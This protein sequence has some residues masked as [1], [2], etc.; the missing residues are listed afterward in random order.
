MPQEERRPAD[1]VLI[2]HVGSATDRTSKGSFTYTGGS[3]FATAFA[4]AAVL[5]GVGLVAQVGDDFDLDV[6]RRLAINMDGVAILPG[7]SA[8][9]II[10]QSRGG[11][12]SFNSVLGVAAE[13]RFDLFPAAYLRARYVH[14]GTAPTG[15]ILAGLFLALCARGLAE[16]RGFDLLGCGDGPVGDRIRGGWSRRDQ[17]AAAGQGRTGSGDNEQRCVQGLRH[18]L[19]LE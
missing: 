2:G 17:R 14:L 8:T 7:T 15:E 11:R 9:F 19:A 1:L 5:G 13:P 4:A 18:G 3:G 12:L 16:D 10:D 6:L